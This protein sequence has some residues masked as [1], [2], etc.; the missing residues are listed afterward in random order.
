MRLLILG[1]TVFLGRAVA[2]HARD[3]GH[4]VTC[5]GRGVSGNVPDGVRLLRVDRDR[6]DGLSPL[7][8]QQFDVVVDVARRPSHVR[9]A[10]AT[11]ADR[12][13]HWT[14]VSTCSVYADHGT[15]GQRAESAP[16]LA[17]APPEMDDAEGEQYGPCKVAA[18]AAV[19]SA[20]V[21]AF[22]CRAGLIVGPEDRS[23]RFDYW[24]ARLERGGEVLAP[25]RPDD[26]VQWIDVRDLAAWL[27]LAAE[28]G[29]T[30]TYDGM[31]APVPRHQFLAGVA[32]GVGVE[33]ML[34]WVDQD[35]LTEHGVQPWSGERSL[36]MWLPLPDYAGFM[37]RDVSPALRTGLVARPLIDTA[38]DTLRWLQTGPDRTLRAGL[39]P[40]DEAN[41]LREWHDQTH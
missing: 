31:G 29:M 25:G 16:L 41:V 9:R 20:G 24:V 19:A 33:P 12:V 21:P 32:E 2:R 8:G 11:L 27:V 26:R 38:R 1:G 39:D 13:G 3:A 15:P 22:V 14:F 5:A 40:D 10:L 23:G 28:T 36:P 35:F 34:T 4:D 18:E 30:G 6:P 7:D 37:T 17:A